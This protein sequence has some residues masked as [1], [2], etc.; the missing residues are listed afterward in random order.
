MKNITPGSNDG[1]TVSANGLAKLEWTPPTLI[2]DA[3]GASAPKPTLT[4]VEQN[5]LA[6]LETIIKKG[7]STFLDVG[8]AL[9]AIHEKRLYRDEYATFETYCKERLGLSRP[10]AYN[11]IGSARVNEQM[12]SIEDIRVKPQ[13]EAQF[14]ELISVPEEK[15][16]EAWKG[17]IKLA[18]EEPVTAT[19]V[20]RAAAKFK[21]E[22][23]G[24]PTAKKKPSGKRI[25]LGPALILL[26]RAEQ[27]A[28]DNKDKVVLKE[29]VAL[30]RCLEASAAQKP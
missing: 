3:L 29:L 27:A 23:P 18:G 25:N 26:A 14:R 15:R 11:L 22:K 1:G 28:S 17:A 5:Q 21:P 19:I 16:V 6:K 7:W 24:K 12:S 10:Y 13:N 30:R 9:L 4:P 8:S 2:I 20:H